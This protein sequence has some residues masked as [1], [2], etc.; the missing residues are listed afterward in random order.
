MSREAA[1]ALCRKYDMPPW[2][3]L[4]IIDHSSSVVSMTCA[5]YKRRWDCDDECEVLWALRCPRWKDALCNIDEFTQEELK[6]FKEA[7]ASLKVLVDW[8]F[9]VST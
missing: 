9:G 6:D 3:I 5:A 7:Y 4:E 2:N 1:L 8:G